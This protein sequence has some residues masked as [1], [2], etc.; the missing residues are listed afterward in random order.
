MARIVKTS[1]PK[2]KLIS[3]KFHVQQLANEVV[4]EIRIKHRWDAI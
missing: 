4:Q 3:E 2:T 1:F